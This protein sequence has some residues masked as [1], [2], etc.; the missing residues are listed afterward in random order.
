MVATW[1]FIAEEFELVETGFCILY[2]T[3]EDQKVAFLFT[4]YNNN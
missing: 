1:S 3:L 2:M 4:K